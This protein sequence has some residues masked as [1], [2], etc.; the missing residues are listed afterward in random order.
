MEQGS[1][2]AKQGEDVA[3]RFSICGEPSSAMH[4]LRTEEP[5]KHAELSGVVDTKVDVAELSAALD[6]T[7]RLMESLVKRVSCELSLMHLMLQGRTGSAGDVEDSD[8]SESDSDSME[9]ARLPT[10]QTSQARKKLF[11]ENTLYEWFNEQKHLLSMIAPVVPAKPSGGLFDVA[12]TRRR[13]VLDAKTASPRD[14]SCF[15]LS[16]MRLGDIEAQVM[17]LVTVA[18]VDEERMEA[19]TVSMASCLERLEALSRE[20]RLHQVQCCQR[21]DDMEA[22][23]TSQTTSLWSK[24][25]HKTEGSPRVS[26]AVYRDPPR[27]KTA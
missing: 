3:R 5:P 8:D 14:Q 2:D 23:L 10:S 12:H 20:A 4:S 21:F 9:D 22:S 13:P 15:H 7:N 1:K 17:K 26:P 27:H 18:A 19:Q 16:E 25:S 11:G 24:G 6:V